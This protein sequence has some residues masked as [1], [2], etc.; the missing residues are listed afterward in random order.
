MK[1]YTFLASGSANADFETLSKEFASYHN[2]CKT[3]GM[4]KLT[5]RFL[6]DKYNLE[7]GFLYGNNNDAIPTIIIKGEK[8]IEFFICD[9]NSPDSDLQIAIGLLRIY[10]GKVSQTN[11]LTFDSNGFP[12]SYPQ[13]PV[14]HNQTDKIEQDDEITIEALRL[15]TILE[16]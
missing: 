9:D 15:K 14:C 11:L 10:H 2:E 5:A 16:T 13:P 7:L 4:A 6:A 1:K 8:K 3:D 12:S